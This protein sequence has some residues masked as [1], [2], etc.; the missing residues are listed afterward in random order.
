MGTDGI[1]NSISDTAISYRLNRLCHLEFDAKT[2]RGGLFY[3]H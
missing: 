3:V 1:S 2:K